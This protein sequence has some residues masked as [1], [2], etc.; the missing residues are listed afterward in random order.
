MRH[1][2]FIC[3]LLSSRVPRV[4]SLAQLVSL[5]QPFLKL[6]FDGLVTL[7]LM[8][9]SKAWWPYETQPVRP[10]VVF[11]HPRLIPS[12]E[13]LQEPWNF[14]QL[15][16]HTLE[17]THLPDHRSTFREPCPWV[18]TIHQDQPQCPHTESHLLSH[19]SNVQ[20]A[21]IPVVLMVKL[22]K[23]HN[24]DIGSWS[25]WTARLWVIIDILTT[26]ADFPVTLR[27]SCM[28]L[29]LVPQNISERSKRLWWSFNKFCQKLDVCFLPDC[30]LTL[31][32]P[33]K[34]NF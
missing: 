28:G 12:D 2:V 6:G 4:A 11:E 29:G 9:L 5:P 33:S 22:L 31:T 32:R 15:L 3:N 1:V 25:C 8:A 17:C 30:R 24:V 34:L 19:H 23:L 18:Q 16:R 27:L 10:R 20:V 13:S 14:L 7:A 26:G 21:V